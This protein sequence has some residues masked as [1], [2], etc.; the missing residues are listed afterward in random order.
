MRAAG[1]GAES[2][3]SS[4]AAGSARRSPPERSIARLCGDGEPGKSEAVHGMPALVHASSVGGEDA[5]SLRRSVSERPASEARSGPAFA[6]D[7]RAPRRRAIAAAGSP[8]SRPSGQVSR[9][10]LCRQ[11]IGIAGGS[12]PDRGQGARPVT[13][14]P[15]ARIAQ[16]F[17]SIRVVVV[18][19]KCPGKPTVTHQ[20]LARSGINSA[21]FRCAAG[22]RVT[23]QPGPRRPCRVQSHS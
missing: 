22:R 19:R 10:T 8:R 20:P 2:A 23:H 5:A 14:H 18:D 15:R 9:A 6:L 12:P 13:H 7:S 4:V 21:R 17:G 3:D 1:T 11:V 16:D